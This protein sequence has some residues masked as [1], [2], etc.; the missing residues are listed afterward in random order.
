MPPSEPTDG[1]PGGS[2]APPRR[3]TTHVNA[4]CHKWQD[5]AELLEDH[6]GSPPPKP[7]RK[8]CTQEEI[9]ADALAAAKV[10]TAKIAEK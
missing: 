8:C 7:R 4:S 3:H 5:D 9:E 1:G 10:K 6:T 2:I